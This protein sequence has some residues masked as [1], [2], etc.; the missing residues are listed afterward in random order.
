MSQ[1]EVESIVRMV[2]R[3]KC[4][5]CCLLELL[6]ES[7]APGFC[8][9]QCPE[10]MELPVLQYASWPS[11]KWVVSL[12][13]LSSIK[14]FVFDTVSRHVAF[15]VNSILCRVHFVSCV[16]GVHIERSERRVQGR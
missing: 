10:V 3:E 14:P 16:Q 7:F 2:S 6:L 4:S 12:E 9:S 1:K 15:P 13:K 5:H 8:S 11:R